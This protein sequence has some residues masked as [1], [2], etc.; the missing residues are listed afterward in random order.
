MNFVGWIGLLGSFV[1]FYLLEFSFSCF[2]FLE[3]YKIKMNPLFI[4]VLGAAVSR[5]GLPGHVPVLSDSVGN[6]S[7][8][9][10]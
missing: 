4:R 8:L 7:L 2:S 10:S 6:G 9:T 3:D 5:R 1:V